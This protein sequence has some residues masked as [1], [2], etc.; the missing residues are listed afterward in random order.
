ML[1]HQHPEHYQC[2]NPSANRERQAPKRPAGVVNAPT[3]AKLQLTVH[4]RVQLALPR[5]T[6]LAPLT[7]GLMIAA[8][9]APARGRADVTASIGFGYH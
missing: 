3:F 6:R 4:E 8:Q 7:R 9:P 5:R 2:A 1:E